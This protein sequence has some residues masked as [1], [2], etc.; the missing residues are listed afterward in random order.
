VTRVTLA[1]A[2]ENQRIKK[3]DD[4]AV[5]KAEA[6][7]AEEPDKIKALALIRLALLRGQIT[8]Q[9][10]AQLSRIATTYP[11]ATLAE[12]IVLA[13]SLAEIGGLDVRSLR[14]PILD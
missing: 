8:P 5:A 7:F 4:V 11:T 14:S 1:L 9:E 2:R 6:A 12:R 10:G 13:Q 3:A